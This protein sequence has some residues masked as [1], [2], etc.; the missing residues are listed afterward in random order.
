[1]LFTPVLPEAASGTLEPRHAVVPLRM[2]C[3]HAEL[4]LGRVVSLDEA[5]HSPPSRPR[6]ASSRSS[7]RTSWSRSAPSRDVSDPG[8]RRARGG[9]QVAGRRDPPAQ[10]RAAGAR[11]RGGRACQDRVSRHL[12]YVFVG[13]G[14]A[15]VEALA[16]LNDLVQDALRYYPRLRHVRQR[17]VLVDAAPHIL[18]EIP[19][20]LGEY[21]ARQLEKRG[22]EIRCGTQLGRRRVAMWCCR[23][24]SASTPGPSSGRRG[25]RQIRCSASSACRSTT[26]V[27]CRS[28]SIY[29]SLAGVTSG[30]SETAP[31][32]RT[33]PLPAA[34]TRRR[35]ST[36]FARRAVWPATWSRRRTGAS[37]SPTATARSA[38]PPRSVATR[39]SPT[40]SACP[41]RASRDGSSP[42]PITSTSCRSS[43][44]SC[45]SSPTG[46]RRSSSDATSPSSERS[47]MA[48]APV[49]AGHIRPHSMSSRDPPEGPDR[50][51]PAR[52]YETAASAF[53]SDWRPDGRREEVAVALHAVEH[54]LHR[55]V[56]GSRL[57]SARPRRAASTPARPGAGAPSRR[58][59]SSRRRRFWF[60]SIEHAAALRLQATPS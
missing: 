39:A 34:P 60:A 44:A 26:A 17:W 42:G 2:M 52:V 5:A 47:G 10:P 24:A 7:T 37:R 20:R 59:R 35:A 58:T 53:V 31:P 46:R 36:R 43:A 3:P 55:E 23:T 1:M 45:G 50:S 8:T 33:P 56:R 6:S 49:G 30:R 51:P 41:Y 22:I 12:A 11:S 29:G 54:D 19:T 40:C 14:Y 16:E 27:G 21:A 32:C 38:R 25:S 57:A 28:T 13:G 9:L 15:G 4:V 18:H 48:A